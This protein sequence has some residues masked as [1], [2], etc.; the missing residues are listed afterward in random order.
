MNPYLQFVAFGI[1]G[2][3]LVF[4]IKYVVTSSIKGVMSSSEARL[5]K[6]TDDSENRLNE[7]TNS[8]NSSMTAFE[9]RIK[10]EIDRIKDSISNVK[11]SLAGDYVTR[12]EF[13]LFQQ[14]HDDS[15]VRVHDRVDA[16]E[17]GLG[18][19]EGSVQACQN[20]HSQS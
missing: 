7:L 6:I 4:L 14:K 1:F 15:I 8:I 20:N 10:D 11:I 18:K 3:L 9:S 5:K 19:L 13:S 16:N 17:K 12:G 2:V